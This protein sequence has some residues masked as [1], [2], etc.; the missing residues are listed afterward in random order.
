M[1]LLWSNP[2]AIIHFP[3]MG[4]LFF[5]VSTSSCTD[6]VFSRSRV[7]SLIPKLSICICASTNPGKIVPFKKI[8]LASSFSLIALIV[9]LSPVAITMSL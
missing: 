9:S 8:F 1:N 2:L 7:N 4:F 6:L 3:S 5:I